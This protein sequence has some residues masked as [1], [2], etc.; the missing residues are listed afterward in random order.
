MTEETYDE[1]LDKVRKE[2]ED[3]LE[4]KKDRVLQLA[5]KLK[6]DSVN[7]EHI[8]KH[9]VNDL[10]DLVSKRWIYRILPDEYKQKEKQHKKEEVGALVHQ[11]TELSN[12][13]GT[14]L[15]GGGPSLDDPNVKRI[16]EDYK[17]TRDENKELQ[18]M[19]EEMQI[20]WKSICPEHQRAITECKTCGEK[21]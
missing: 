20:K 15:V 14:I 11:T 16:L 17:K 6:N 8:A 4:K 13:D 7:P 18:S 1:L 9:V 12:E 19:L 3:E 2:L 5:E 10:D 21:N